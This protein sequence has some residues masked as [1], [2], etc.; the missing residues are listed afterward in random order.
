MK[1]ILIAAV[2]AIAGSAHAFVYS[3]L[4]SADL[5][6]IGISGT[7]VLT[8]TPPN[9]IGP[10]NTTGLIDFFPNNVFAGGASGQVT[11][12]YAFSYDVNNPIAIK[13]IGLVLLGTIGGRGIV[14]FS[15]QVQQLVGGVPTGPNLVN[16][17]VSFN[18]STSDPRLNVSGGNYN[19]LDDTGLFRG[20]TGG[21]APQTDYRVFKEITVSVGTADYNHATDFA[22]VTLVEQDHQ[23]VPE[24]A[25]FAAL[26]LGAIVLIRRRRR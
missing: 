18:S 26:G 20:A 3:N 6:L 22:S 12:N 7:G 1:K 2:L 9:S 10:G 17:T 15:E 23:P 13:Q 5:A 25:S 11:V 19:F 16:Y 14:T 24:P 21:L 8:V 4:T